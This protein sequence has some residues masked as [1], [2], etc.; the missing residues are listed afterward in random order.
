MITRLR[1]KTFMKIQQGRVMKIRKMVDGVS[2]TTLSY[3]AGFFDGE[4]SIMAD[5]RQNY[6]K[7]SKSKY[8]RSRNG[9]RSPTATIKLCNTDKKPVELI[10]KIFGGKILV[11][12]AK[13]GNRNKPL[14]TYRAYENRA[15]VI[16]ETL[17]PYL[18]AKKHH[19]KLA[20][21]IYKLKDKIPFGRRGNH[22]KVL[23]MVN[24]LALMN[25]RNH[26]PPQVIK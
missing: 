15:R 14:F 9:K 10:K 26:L 25:N 24:Q 6:T 16:L 18:I 5:R 19:A 4:G 20:L 1:K 7:N 23:E 2:G 17:L 11:D 12:D 21:R 3:L 13:R 22:P 8:H